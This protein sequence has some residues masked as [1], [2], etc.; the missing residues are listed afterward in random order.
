M[1][2]GDDTIDFPL[3]SMEAARG[4]FPPE[5]FAVA[6]MSAPPKSGFAVT[7][8]TKGVPRKF[9]GGTTQKRKHKSPGLFTDH[10]NKGIGIVGK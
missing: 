3:L 4:L 9:A 7:Q 2:Y 6:T 8:F 1:N 10:L 5:A